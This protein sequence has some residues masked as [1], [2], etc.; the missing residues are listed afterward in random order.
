M[1]SVSFCRRFGWTRCIRPDLC[2][3]RSI[4]P[5]YASSCP[6]SDH[7]L[8]AHKLCISSHVWYDEPQSTT[9]AHQQPS[10][11]SLAHSPNRQRKPHLFNPRFLFS[12]RFRAKALAHQAVV[13]IVTSPSFPPGSRASPFAH[14]GIPQL[15]DS[16]PRMVSLAVK[17]LVR[18]AFSSADPESLRVPAVAGGSGTKFRFAIYV[19]GA[20]GDTCAACFVL[21]KAAL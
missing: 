17:S 6:S 14:T 5:K 18:V 7:Y 15:T 16:F 11:I 13:P 10:P 8:A 4:K 9:T 1:T 20:E 19:Y 3:I 2:A 21:E 12:H